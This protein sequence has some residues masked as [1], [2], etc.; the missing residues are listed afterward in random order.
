MGGVFSYTYDHY[1]AN[2]IPVKTFKEYEDGTITNDVLLERLVEHNRKHKYFSDR[3]TE[4]LWALN[5]R[6]PSTLSQEEIHRQYQNAQ[7]AHSNYCWAQEQYVKRGLAKHHMDLLLR[8]CAALPGSL[9]IQKLV[10]QLQLLIKGPPR[11]MPSQEQCKRWKR[12]S[13][14]RRVRQAQ[15]EFTIAKKKL[16][17][18]NKALKRTRLDS[19]EY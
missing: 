13:T 19:E 10:E 9:V 4:L 12:Q 15:R 16:G 2:L 8:R 6:E 3:R 18:A 1:P 14:E 17:E 11:R 7:N 5:G